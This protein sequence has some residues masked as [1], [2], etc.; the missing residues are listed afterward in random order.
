MTLAIATEP[1]PLKSNEDGVVLV[2][3]TRVTLDTV[4]AAFLEGAT[5][6]EIVEQYPSLQL[7]DVYSAIA[8]YLRRKAEVDAY[9]KIRQERASQVRQENER[10]FN[11]IGI[12]DRLLA[13]LEHQKQS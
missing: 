11:P 2:G 5:A 13:R 1:T 9:I 8:Y 6:E 7:A 4:V 10:R 3:N 12:H